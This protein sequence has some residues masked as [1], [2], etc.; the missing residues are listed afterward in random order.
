VN[1]STCEADG[2][3]GSRSIMPTAAKG[4][5]IGVALTAALACVPQDNAEA[6]AKAVTPE[7]AQASPSPD[8]QNLLAAA[9]TL[10]RSASSQEQ[11]RLLAQL[12]SRQFL[13]ELDSPEESVRLPALKLRLARVLEAL[14]AN[15]APAARVTLL[16]LIKSRDFVS[17]DSRQ[18]LLLRALSSVR[19]PTDE[20][21]Q[22]WDELSHP[23]SIHLSFVIAALCE[24]GTPEAMSLLERKLADPNQDTQ[25]KL[26]WMRDPILRHRNDLQ[27]LRGCERMIRSS[28]PANLRPFLVEA[29]FDYR[30]N[31]WYRY[32]A[33]PTP[34]PRATAT[35]EAKAQLKKIGQIALQD[36]KLDA[37]QKQ[38]VRK[39]LE[40]IQ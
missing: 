3:R 32:E 11:A 37:R 28:L 35:P 22:F 9:L 12:S 7:T 4:L 5:L 18:E 38:V 33:P 25:V 31:I 17:Y 39:V 2:L 15:P 36:V 34:P 20:V 26:S 14:A 6:P 23:D 16:E 27:L 1:P 21:I 10:A 19:P 13:N 8:P 40:E 29:L 30:K 24:N